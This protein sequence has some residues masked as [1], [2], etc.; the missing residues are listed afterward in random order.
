MGLRFK[1]SIKI[2]KGAKINLG[3]TGVS[4]SVGTRGAHYTVHSSGKKTT[5]VG[6]PGTG[7]SYV[8]TSGGGTGRRTSQSV[9]SAAY[10]QRQR[11]Q[12]TQYAQNAEMIKD[13]NDLIDQIRSIHKESN[14]YVDWIFLRDMPEPFDPMYRGPFEE[15]AMENAGNAKPALLG[16]L[17]PLIDKKKE[18]KYIEA[19]NEAREKDLQTYHDWEEKRNLAEKVLSGD[20]DSYYYVISI[21]HPFDKILD[22]GSDFDIGTDDPDV[23]EVEFHAK[24]SKV[25]PNH[26]LSLTKAGNLSSKAMSKTMHYDI[27]QDY[28]CSCVLRI[29]REMFSLLPISRVI[30]H[31]EDTVT[32]STG[33]ESDNTVLS[34]S[35]RREQLED[36][37]F[38]MID[39]SDTIE[40]FECNMDFKKTK[41][42][43]PVSR[44]TL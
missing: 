8:S 24:T 40:L 17:I 7:L 37:D 26:V 25:V 29:A 14:E 22:F 4:L 41:G 42:L 15:Q 2:S 3:K 28:I 16:R 44:I 32:D 1:R 18:K 19:I 43:L 39:P 12:E 36:I 34:V 9:S 23:L 13:Y 5:S 20:I 31:V 11:E 35:I 6:L 21:A 38:D 33:Y 27:A 10:A 30:I